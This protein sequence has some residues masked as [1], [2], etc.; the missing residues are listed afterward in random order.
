MAFSWSNP[1]VSPIAIDLGIDSVKALQIVPGESPQVIAAACVSVP[2][3]VR[4]DPT[5]RMAF[6]NEAMRDLL[7]SA[8]FKGKR[9]AFAIPAIQTLVQ[10]LQITKVEGE[11]LSNQVGLM[12]RQ[13]LNLDPARLVMRPVQVGPVVRDG[14]SKHEVICLAA[15]RE[16]VMR[17]LSLASAHKLDV[18]GM[19][20]EPLAIIQAF[21]HL[22]RRPGDEERTT[23]FIDIGAGTTK[24]LIAHGQN[25]VFAKHINVAG[26]H[27]TRAL[28]QSQKIEF[29]QARQT[30]LRFADAAETHTAP[31]RRGTPNGVDDLDTEVSP[32]NLTTSLTGPATATAA[33]PSDATLLHPETL[34]SVIEEVQLCVRYHQSLFPGRVIEKLVFIGGEA[35]QVRLCQKIARAVRIGA[36]LGDPLARLAR[37]SSAKAQFG[38]DL[39]QPQPGW[40][41]PVGLCTLNTTDGK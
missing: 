22:Y 34:E 10:H 24:V 26:D 33:R 27:F 39:Q 9:V 19:H 1:R 5:L 37:P 31:I 8:P 30:R 21:V 29:D 3:Q 28:A 7:R 16:T 40:S 38:V 32:S 6:Y 41:V 36:Q 13:K 11:E 2:G 4:A 18:V 35:R 23:C 14:V 12:L 15:S 17:I 20:C 25:L